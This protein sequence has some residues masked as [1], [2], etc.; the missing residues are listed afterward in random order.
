M[1]M[2][3]CDRG[4]SSRCS[5]RRDGRVV[6]QAY[7]IPQHIALGRLDQ[8]SLLPDGEVRFCVDTG[9]VWFERLDDVVV[10][11]DQ[12]RQRRP[13]LSL[14]V[15]GLT[16]IFADVATRRRP[17]GRR[18]LDATAYANIVHHTLLRSSTLLT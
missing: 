9:E 3:A 1:G 16:P 18:V 8:E 4:E 12:I 15:D 6:E 7:T 2:R 11:A 17:R 14:P 10:V 5:H 13:P